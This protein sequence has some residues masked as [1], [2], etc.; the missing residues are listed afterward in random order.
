MLTPNILENN[1]LNKIRFLKIFVVENIFSF[2]NLKKKLV[3]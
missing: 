1:K 2:Q 3:V